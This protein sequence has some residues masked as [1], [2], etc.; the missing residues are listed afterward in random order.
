MLNL[1]T[2]KEIK[3][4]NAEI[5]TNIRHK[6]AISD[7][8]KSIISAENT[9]NDGMTIDITAIYFKE[10]IE[11]LNKITGEDVTDDIINDIFSKFCLGK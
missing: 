8:L 11:N 6:D 4:E 10:A 3:A 1:F 5:I 9:I 7:A 2:N